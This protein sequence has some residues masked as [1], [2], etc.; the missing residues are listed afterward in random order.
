MAGDI[1]LYMYGHYVLILPMFKFLGKEVLT[2]ICRHVIPL[3]CIKGQR[4]IEEVPT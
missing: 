1:S 2:R 3:T 4:I